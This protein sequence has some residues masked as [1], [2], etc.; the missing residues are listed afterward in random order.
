MRSLLL[1]ALL[2]SCKSEIKDTR[3]IQRFNQLVDQ[4]FS[5]YS[6]MRPIE[7]TMTGFHSYDNQL[8]KYDAKAMADQ[9]AYMKSMLQQLD[10]LPVD[11]LDA[12]SKRDRLI[13]QNAMRAE[14]IDLEDYPVWKK[15]P[16]FYNDI[17]NDS[18]LRLIEGVAAPKSERLRLVIERERQI[19]AFLETAKANLDHPPRALVEIAIDQFKG[20]IT[21]FKDVVPQAFADSSATELVGDLKQENA[22]VI[23]ACEEFIDFLEKKVLPSSTEE[24]ALGADL[25]QKKLRYREMIE[26]PVTALEERGLGRL[27]QVQSEFLETAKKIDAGKPPLQVLET[28]TRDHP[29]GEQ[30]IPA[31]RRLLEEMRTFCISRNL[32]TIPSEVRCEVTETAPFART[33]SLA[34][35]DVPGS[36]EPFPLEA[37]LKVTLPDP[38]WTPDRREGHLRFFN[39]AALP[40]ITAFETYPGRYLQYLWSKPVPSKVRRMLPSDFFRSGWAHYAEQLVLDEGY[41]NN[42]PKIQLAQS[43]NS[44]LRLARF[45]T[46]IGLHTRKM[47][48]S[49]AIDFYVREA[50]QERA[51]AER[52]TRRSITSPMR[53]MSYAWGKLEIFQLREEYRQKKGSAFSLKE[54]HNELLRHGAPPLPTLRQILFEEPE[55]PA[56]T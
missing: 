44:L 41:R 52:E 1:L 22:K 31:I 14:L 3:D 27:R 15:N 4:Y 47:T 5:D 32:V 7:A 21:F 28:V 24:F 40:T 26:Q 48:P 49:Q 45:L 13:L 6:R 29:S 33:L 50:Y 20:T 10:S 8:G 37:Y 55:K 17:L 56:G 18:I 9:A 34:S 43:R 23:Q 51:N 46:A 54:F 12:S 36:Y 2:V 53:A 11:R 30:L 38:A 39:Y 42:D 25:L 19:P 16:S 35:L